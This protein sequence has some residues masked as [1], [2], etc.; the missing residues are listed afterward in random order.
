MTG[1][2][3][4][5]IV[6]KFYRLAEPLGLGELPPVLDYEPE[7][8]AN[9]EDIY[10]M[11]VRMNELFKHPKGVIVYSNYHFWSQ[12]TPRPTWM[13][14]VEWIKKWVASWT[15]KS[16][17]TMPPGWDTWHFWQ[18]N[19]QNT[20]GPR[21][22]VKSAEVDINRFNGTFEEFL[23]WGRYGISEPPEP[24]NYGDDI[25]EIKDRIKEISAQV[26]EQKMRISE[27]DGLAVSLL[28]RVN[29][30]EEMIKLSQEFEGRLSNKLERLSDELEQLKNAQKGTGCLP[31]LIQEINHMFQ[32]KEKE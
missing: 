6:E 18:Y 27:L 30:L 24:P 9:P 17:P 26:I 21:Y 7:V 22:G 1:A 23:K 32:R 29:S 31:G 16:D 19:T 14:G 12:I 20:L 25:A 4:V 3:P 8:P 15:T 11:L 5:E 2:N 10:R 28:E 13:T